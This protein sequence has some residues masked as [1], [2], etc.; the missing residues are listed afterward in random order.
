LKLQ[1]SEKVVK[2]GKNQIFGIFLN[3]CPAQSITNR[4]YFRAL[5]SLWGLGTNKWYNLKVGILFKRG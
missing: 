5:F 4:E 2:N 1:P 3:S